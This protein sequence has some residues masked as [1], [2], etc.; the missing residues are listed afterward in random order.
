MDK[1]KIS[2]E[3]ESGNKKKRQMSNSEKLIRAF[4]RLVRNLCPRDKAEI[5]RLVVV[6]FA[7]VAQT[8]LLVWI[9]TLTVNRP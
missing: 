8:Y 3:I 6:V 5:S 7:L 4:M 1:M 9:L 2:F